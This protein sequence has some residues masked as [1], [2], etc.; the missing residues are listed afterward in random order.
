MGAQR[1]R[2]RLILEDHS[3]LGNVWLTSPDGTCWRMLELIL[4]CR[5][6]DRLYAWC[7]KTCLVDFN[8]LRSTGFS[9]PNGTCWWM[10]KLILACGTHDRAVAA[11][12]ALIP[13]L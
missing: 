5:A 1:P 11:A 4:A 2:E 3:W 6:H 8:W 13:S 9:A 7:F 12:W 10:H